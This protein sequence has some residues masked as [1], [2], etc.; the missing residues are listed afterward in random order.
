MFTSLTTGPRPGKVHVVGALLGVS[1]GM[2]GLLRFLSADST[3]TTERP[4][5]NSQFANIGASADAIW[6]ESLPLPPAHPIIKS[7]RRCLAQEQRMANEW[8]RTDSAAIE[9]APPALQS[10]SHLAKG[11]LAVIVE[12]KQRALDLS[13]VRTWPHPHPPALAVKGDPTHSGNDGFGLVSTTIGGS[14]LIFRI[15]Q[16]DEPAAFTA[17]HAA[18][19]ELARISASGSK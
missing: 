17:I 18:S 11:L 10:A 12:A 15:E 1:I 4:S 8:V 19:E 5:F 6:R 3:P 16:S 13:R 2:W 14:C 7:V 9:Q